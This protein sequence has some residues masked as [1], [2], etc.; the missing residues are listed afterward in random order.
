MR[1]T[2]GIPWLKNNTPSKDAVLIDR[3][4]RAGA[5]VFGKTNL[6]FS[7]YNWQCDNPL[8]GRCHH[9]L[10]KDYNPG[11]SSG[12]SCAAVAAYLSP[13]ELGSD[14]AGSIRY[15][16][17]ACG[18]FGLRTTEGLLDGRGHGNVPGST[19][20]MADFLSFGP[21]ARHL[22]DL[23]L[24]LRV[25]VPKHTPLGQCAWHGTPKPIKGARI[26]WTETF[27]GVSLTQDTKQTLRGFLEKL[28]RLG[29][30]VE[31]VD[32]PIDT[33]K[34]M[35]VWGTVHGVQL[36]A[37]YPWAA[38][39]WLGTAMA[40]RMYF[41]MLFGPS[42]FTD[43]VGKG[44]RATEQEYFQAVHQRGVFL[45]EGDRFFDRWDLWVTPVAST[46]ARPYQSP[47]QGV[48]VDD[49]TVA[50]G[51]SV[52]LFSCPTTATGH[53]VLVV[54]AGKAADGMPIGL[55]LHGRRG[56]DF[57]LLAMAREILAAS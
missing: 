2:S 47:R 6:P 50:Y 4:K 26:A 49:T 5:I 48:P 57:A 28:R 10:R 55:Q 8:F 35:E 17:H 23:E 27:G 36:R 42:Q 30:R 24:A 46:P 29:A 21:I 19:P 43:V 34:A 31:S 53:P 37:A 41:P 20:A 40:K 51:D 22:D 14:V 15:P 11:G 44:F 39:T 38:R 1:T 18:V 13:L 33:R 54:P 52:A 25:L 7:S 12:G 45:E 9:P 32:A 16:A 56:S 3:L